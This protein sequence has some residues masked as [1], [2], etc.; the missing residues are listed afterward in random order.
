MNKE[1]YPL[2]DMEPMIHRALSMGG[3]FTFYPCG[4]SMLPTIR[5]G[6]DQVILTALPDRLRRYQI[7][8]YKRA[9][10]AYVL[11]RIVGIQGD[12]YVMRGD[13]QYVNEPGIRREQMIAMAGGIVQDKKVIDPNKGRARV[14]DI[15]WVESAQIRRLLLRVRGRCARLWHIIKK[16]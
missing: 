13:N 10:G 2:S 15:L 6:R 1:K 11:H 12:S 14:Q 9:D 5:E 16:K 4:T 7:I 8:L 3:T